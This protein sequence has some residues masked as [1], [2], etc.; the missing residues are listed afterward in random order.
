[1]TARLAAGGRVAAAHGEGDGGTES[2]GTAM[3]EKKV[4]VEAM[5]PGSLEGSETVDE[6]EEDFG[7]TE[8][9]EAEARGVATTMGDEENQWPQE[10]ELLFDRDRPEMVKRE[11]ERRFE[12]AG[13]QVGV[14]LKEE[15][16]DGE[17]FELSEGG[18]VGPGVDRGSGDGDEVE[19]KDPECPANVKV[20]EAM[21]LTD[22]VP[23]AACNE[24]AGE[25]EKETHR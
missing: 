8:D 20:A 12:S 4:I 24:K 16:E 17:R 10:I 14:V 3:R 22:G 21:L 13:C 18:A 19:R 11:G 6:V 2:E 1:M 9:P 5:H 15:D 7:N 25:R 23:L